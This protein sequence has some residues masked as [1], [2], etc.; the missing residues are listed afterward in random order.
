MKL[1]R[2]VFCILRRTCGLFFFWLQ[3]TLSYSI[4][5]NRDGLRII[6]NKTLWD[7]CAALNN[8]AITKEKILYMR[9]HLAEFPF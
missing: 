5:L 3:S 9:I 4:V 8:K 2:N 6:E 1:A 7:G